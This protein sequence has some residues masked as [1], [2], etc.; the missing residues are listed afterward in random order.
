MAVSAK[1]VPDSRLV[2]GVGDTCKESTVISDSTG[3]TITC[4]YYKRWTNM[5]KRCYKTYN[6]EWDR[7]KTYTTCTVCDDWLLFPKFKAWMRGQHWEGLELDKD[8]LIRGNK[9]YSPEACVFVP[10]YLNYLLLDCGGFTDGERLMGVHTHSKPRKKQ[11]Y[12]RIRATNIDGNNTNRYL[13]S[14]YR[15]ED[16]HKAWQA[17]KIGVIEE[18]LAIYKQEMFFNPDVENALV[19]VIETISED[20]SNGKITHKL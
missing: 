2:F 13:G 3:K 6:A 12:S 20:V 17:A 1:V 5:L 10:K 11:F 19:S 18:T 15:K 4:P 7:T 9:I 14:F 8:I 16:A